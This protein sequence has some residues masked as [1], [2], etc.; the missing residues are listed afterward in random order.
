M[1]AGKASKAVLCAVG[2]A[3]LASPAIAVADTDLGEINGYFYVG[4]TSAVTGYSSVDAACPTGAHVAGGGFHSG[5]PTGNR[6]FD[7]PDHD[8]RPDDGWTYD[9]Y[10]STGT[11]DV[12]AI[13][14][15]GRFAYVK[16]SKRIRAGQVQTATVSCPRGTRVVSGGGVPI[17][18]ATA[19][20]LDTS[21]PFDDAD[22]NAL[23][24]DGWVVRAQSSTDG[25]LRAQAVCAD[26]R[27]TYVSNSFALPPNGSATPI[28]I[29]PTDRQLVG[30]GGRS[31]SAGATGYLFGLEPLDGD[32]ADLVPD[33][34]AQVWISN[35]SGTAESAEAFAICML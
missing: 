14:S 33:D 3:T 13:C 12:F 19:D 2:L 23:P 17:R 32:D 21:A 8:T 18:G 34:K 11:S 1:R 16:K 31:L 5:V 6:P 24:E 4:D 27:P 20:F 22:A 35:S 9:F 28:V 15:A 30:I 29:C 10:Q 25:K 7:G 26:V